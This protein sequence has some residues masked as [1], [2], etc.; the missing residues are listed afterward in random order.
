MDAIFLKLKG[1]DG[2]SLVKGFEKQTEIMAYSH[3][4]AMQVTNDV[5]NTERTSGRAHVGE[6]SLTKYIDLATPVLNEYC[7][8]GKVI[9]TAE[10]TLCRNDN[11]NMLPFIIYTL[12]NVIISYLGVNGGNNGKPVESMSLNFTKI[13]WEITSQKSAGQKEGNSSSLWDMTM[14]QKGS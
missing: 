10:L 3:S 6:F 12:T 7:C 11:G 1:I 13:K 14:N 9:P 2:E 8:C 4:V 5:S